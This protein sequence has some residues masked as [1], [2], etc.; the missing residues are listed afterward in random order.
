MIEQSIKNAENGVAITKEV[1]E[2]LAEIA[3]GNRKVNDL[4]GE[5]AAASNEQAQGIEQINTAMSQMDTVTQS[6]AANAEESASA[7]EELSAQ[8]DELSSM[9]LELQK[10]VGGASKLAK[11]TAARQPAKHL[12]LTHPQ[13]APAT[14]GKAGGKSTARSTATRTQAA[15]KKQ[16]ASASELIPLED[17]A[18]LAR[19]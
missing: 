6:N 8:A 11:S 16:A 3:T 12:H 19:F 10:M 13:A 17:H 1:G 2:S 14:S 5:I 18:E 15:Q 7:A 9:V 4:I